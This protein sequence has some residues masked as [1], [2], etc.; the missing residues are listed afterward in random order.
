MGTSLSG[1]ARGVSFC[2]FKGK[3]EQRFD[4]WRAFL[5]NVHEPKGNTTQLNS[6]EHLLSSWCLFHPA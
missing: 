6:Y 3:D 5:V 4:P 2:R 1:K